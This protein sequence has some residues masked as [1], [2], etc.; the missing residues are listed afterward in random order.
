MFEVEPEGY[1]GQFMF[2]K[3]VTQAMNADLSL[4]EAE[5]IKTMLVK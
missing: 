1:C 2:S 3:K 5:F 4:I